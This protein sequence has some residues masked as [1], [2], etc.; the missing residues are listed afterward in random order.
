MI[1]GFLLWSFLTNFGMMT[2]RSILPLT[3]VLV[4]ACAPNL[5]IVDRYA[6]N[7]KKTVEVLKGNGNEARV[8][9]RIHYYSNGQIKSEISISNG[10]ANG[11][12]ITFHS[13]GAVA[14]KGKFYSGKERGKCAW[15]NEKGSVDSI[16]SYQNGILHGKTQYYSGEKLI[17]SQKYSDGEL[18][19]KFVEN[20]PTGSK[21]VSGNYLNDLPHDKWIWWDA[22]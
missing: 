2:I 21:K 5:R 17:K 20:Y 9:K 22:D 11:K 19:G 7:E 1:S 6:M 14:S 18:N 10:E 15:T 16:H 8:T 3:L 4:L 13:N 12:F